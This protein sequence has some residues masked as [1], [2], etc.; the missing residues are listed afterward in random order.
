LVESRPFIE[1]SVGGGVSLRASAR[2]AELWGDG[3]SA[4][5]ERAR[6]LLEGP[7]AALVM[8]CRGLVVLHGSAVHYGG[9]TV[10]F[11]GPSGAGKSTLSAYLCKHGFGLGS[12]GVTVIDPGSRSI[13]ERRLAWKLCPDSMEQLGHRPE[14]HPFA[15]YRRSK[16]SLKLGV[17]HPSDCR[18]DIA[19]VL[20]EG[21]E[22]VVQEY[23]TKS[24]ATVQLL[25]NYYL[26]EVMPGSELPIMLKR[27]AVLVSSGLR[28][29]KLSYS[30]DWQS[31]PA[32]QQ[33]IIED[34]S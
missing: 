7:G 19:Y 3:A 28:V 10:V 29:A 25:R 9:K 8:H 27:I 15:D 18:L 4:L 11:V 31:L 33:A 2:K 12:D 20:A 22:T 30:R 17:S 14:E 34:I 5:G 21:P 6:D 26:A 32:V 23:S 16:H 1:I 24:E 13:V